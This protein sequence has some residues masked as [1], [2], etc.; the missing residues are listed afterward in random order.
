MVNVLQVKATEK[1]T[2]NE[3]I[4]K[5]RGLKCDECFTSQSHF[6]RHEDDVPFF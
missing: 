4:T 2:L 3:Y 1:D 6:Q 5:I